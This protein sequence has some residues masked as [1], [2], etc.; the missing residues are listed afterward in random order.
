MRKPMGSERPV[1]PIPPPDPRATNLTRRRFLATLGAS[2][3]GTAVAAMG[4]LPGVAAA[5]AATPQATDEGSAYRETAH[6]RDYY[7]TAKI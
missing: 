5:Q 1:A 7:R 4:A 2:G 3:A 6:V